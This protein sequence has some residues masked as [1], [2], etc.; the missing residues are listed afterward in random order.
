MAAKPVFK[1]Q[2]TD[3]ITGEIVAKFGGNSPLE[4]DLCQ[5]IINRTMAIVKGK[6]VGMLKTQSKVE[7]EIES[8]VTEAVYEALKALKQATIPL[9]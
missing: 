7:A 6:N 4:I 1:L 8:A 5:D 2:I 9:V 3:A